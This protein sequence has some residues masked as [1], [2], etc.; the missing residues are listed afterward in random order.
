[1]EQRSVVTCDSVQ[2][3]WSEASYV[4][5]LIVNKRALEHGNS[6]SFVNLCKVD[7]YFDTA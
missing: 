6:Y 4:L 1:M 3:L 7:F 5:C 2:E